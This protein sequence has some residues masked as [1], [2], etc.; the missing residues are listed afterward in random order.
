VAIG[1]PG[2]TLPP[3]GAAREYVDH[4][5][6]KQRIR[7][8]VTEAQLIV[9][10]AGAT[11]GLLWELRLI[12]EMGR[13]DRVLM[14]LPQMAAARAAAWA[15][16]RE[17]LTLVSAKQLPGDHDVVAKGLLVSLQK[18]GEVAL[19]T[20]NGTERSYREALGTV[21][22]QVRRPETAG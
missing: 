9:V 14:V 16:I 1:R 17:V 6:W 4:G 13:L 19:L 18:D 15:G 11:E 22:A 21:M 2:E 12:A 20:G 5:S 3:L 7:E 8:L 10:L